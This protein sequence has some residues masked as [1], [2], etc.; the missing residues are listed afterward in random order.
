MHCIPGKVCISLHELWA[1]YQLV[2]LL[3]ILR[4]EMY[5]I[6]L[7]CFKGEYKSSNLKFATLGR[8]IFSVAIPIFHVETLLKHV[9]QKA[10][11]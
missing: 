9:A 8:Q 11:S 6:N 1:V 4:D 7:N 10:S 5:Y 3:G 2:A